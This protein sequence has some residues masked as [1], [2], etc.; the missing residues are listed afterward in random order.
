MYNLLKTIRDSFL[1]LVFPTKCIHCHTLL[2][3]DSTILCYSCATLLEMI[4]PEER[5]PTCF[6]LQADLSF[7]CHHCIDYPP[8]YSGSASAFDYEGPAASL[9]KCLKYKNQPYLSQGMGA[10]LCMQFD[11]LGW[12]TPSALVPVPLSFSH[13]LERGYNQ[14][15]LLAN[16][17]GQLINVPV[18][19]VLKRKS[20]DFSQAALTLE[21]R[22]ELSSQRFRL[23]SSYS[24]KGET[25]LIIDDVMTSGSTLQRCAEILNANGAGPLYALTF[26]RTSKSG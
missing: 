24:V 22:R 21:Q 16:E 17:L 8:L 11:Q 5:C 4:D 6:N 10:F 9:V 12:P 1:H 25:L 23:N 13:W 20:G 2:S 18:W 14:S 26:C 15:E 19:N 3:P 7:L